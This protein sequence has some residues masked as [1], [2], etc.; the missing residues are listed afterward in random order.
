MA[1]HRVE[2]AQPSTQVV[3]ADVRFDVYADEELLG[4]LTVSKGTIDWRPARK[5]TA[6]Q[7]S[8]ERFA[9]LMDEA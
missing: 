1:E 9:R 2:M 7:L 6:R 5:H 3:N 4:V 8:W